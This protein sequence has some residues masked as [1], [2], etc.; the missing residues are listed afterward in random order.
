MWPRAEGLRA[1]G[2][3]DSGPMR[4]RLTALTL[5]G[6]KVATGDLWQQGYVD[7]GEAL[8]EIGERLAVLDDDDQVVAIIEI[9]RVVKHRFDDVPWEF[10]DAEGEGFTS[11]EHWREGH[12]SYFAKRG[13]D[14]DDASIFVCLWYRLVET[15][16]GR[17]SDSR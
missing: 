10:A 17:V 8:E 7:E 12:R 9:T 15:R 6:T 13:V 16:Q 3:G 2:F 4:E 11:I 1:F 14:V 5:A